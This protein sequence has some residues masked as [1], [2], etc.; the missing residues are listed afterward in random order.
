MRAA[1]KRRRGTARP[2][3]GKLRELLAAENVREALSRRNVD[4][5]IA[6]RIGAVIAVVLFVL[7]IAKVTI[8]GF[9]HSTH[10]DRSA[11]RVESEAITGA[12]PAEAPVSRDKHR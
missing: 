8:M 2:S 5:R 9:S 6:M 4:T 12:P 7:L 11:R 1:S 10:D 3:R